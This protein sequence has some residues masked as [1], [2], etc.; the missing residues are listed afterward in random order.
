MT[1]DQCVFVK[2]PA[3]KDLQYILKPASELTMD[4]LIPAYIQPSGL[5]PTFTP[6][7]Y[8]D[9]IEVE[10]SSMVGIETSAGH[11]LQ[12]GVLIPA[13]GTCEGRLAKKQLNL[14]E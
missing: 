9:I 6:L 10:A 13:S 4:D 14:I 11:Y 5:F 8:L 12:N 2:D 3:S 7:M 1:L